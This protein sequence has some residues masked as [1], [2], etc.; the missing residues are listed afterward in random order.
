MD[1]ARAN[2]DNRPARP[3]AL[4]AKG[5]ATVL[6]S[7]FYRV[8]S[9]PL[10]TLVNCTASVRGSALCSS[11]PGENECAARRRMSICGSGGKGTFATTG[12]LPTLTTATS[13]PLTEIC[14]A[15]VSYGTS[16]E[17][18][19]VSAASLACARGR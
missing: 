6:P 7:M 2:Y 8:D 12:C 15:F 1:Y 3:A 5:S 13:R 9:E 14:T 10:T 4:V 11:A 18:R 19:R 16:L 17:K